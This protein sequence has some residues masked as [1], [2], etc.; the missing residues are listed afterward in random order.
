MVSFALKREHFGSIEVDGLI[1]LQCTGTFPSRR[2]GGAEYYFGRAGQTEGE[3]EQ[4][5]QHDE[6]SKMAVDST[7]AVIRETVVQGKLGS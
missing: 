6:M 5:F 7:I 1:E 2:T 4:V 3:R